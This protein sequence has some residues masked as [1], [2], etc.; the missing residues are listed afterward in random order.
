MHACIPNI[1]PKQQ[2]R[3][4]I[5]GG[6][7]LVAAAALAATLAAADAPVAMRAIVALPLYGAALGFF[8]H[9]EKT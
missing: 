5:L 7:G 2:R 1:G 6:L 4:L 8:Q 3:R 9:R